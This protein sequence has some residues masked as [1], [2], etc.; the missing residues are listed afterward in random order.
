MAP[1]PL[2][3]CGEC[4]AMNLPQRAACL[5]CGA[6]LQ[7]FQADDADSESNGNALAVELITGEPGAGVTVSWNPIQA[8]QVAFIA[9]CLLVAG[10]VSYYLIIAKP[11]META[12][13]EQRQREKADAEAHTRQVAL[14]N[15]RSNTLTEIIPTRGEWEGR[16]PARPPPCPATRTRHRD[17]QSRGPPARHSHSV[18]GDAVTPESH[19]HSRIYR[20]YLASP[21][22]F[23]PV[24]PHQLLSIRDYYKVRRR[25]VG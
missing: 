23:E 14:S 20:E 18:R 16:W 1:T 12:R 24:Q 17:P 4:S 10:S 25:K 7:R 6:A 22:G 11:R 8:M 15:E 9:S 3:S 19:R 2:V 13:L 21:T 5:R